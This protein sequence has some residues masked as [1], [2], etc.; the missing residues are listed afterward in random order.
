MHFHPTSDCFGAC[1]ANGSQQRNEEKE[2]NRC[3]HSR[4]LTEALKTRLA[5]PPHLWLPV[6]GIAHKFKKWS[7]CGAKQTTVDASFV[8]HECHS[9]QQ[10]GLSGLGMTLFLIHLRHPKCITLSLLLNW[11]ELC[12]Y[13]WYCSALQFGGFSCISSTQ[14]LM[15]VCVP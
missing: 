2:A 11:Q 7:C 8:L 6:R 10:A 1:G 5:A 3:N 9:F 15:A 14:A 4:S 12:A 13:S